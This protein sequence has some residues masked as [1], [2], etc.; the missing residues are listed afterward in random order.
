ME[1]R[2]EYLLESYFSNSL[3]EAEAAE[4]KQ[5]VAKDPG[6][7]EELSFQQRLASSL[8]KGALANS[9]QNKTWREAAKKPFSG[10]ALKIRMW[11]RYAIATAAAIALFLVAR[12]ALQT[13][14]LM[15]VVSE[16]TKEY[17]NTMP[18]KSLSDEA[19]R[20]PGE[21]IAAFALYDDKSY[22]KAATALEAIA[23]AYPEESDY[24]FY[25]GV[26]LVHDKQYDKAKSALEPLVQ[27][28]AEKSIPAR[29]YLG[30]AC[31]GT[32]DKDCAR[33]N[34]QSYVDSPEGV[35]YRKNAS[36]VLEGL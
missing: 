4:L 22:T 10:G 17:P 9:I 32:G 24:R 21:V 3:T 1:N 31:A 11:S 27:S 33:R 5:L 2:A 20:Y 16:N 30:L 7:A 8:Q 35:T 23:T 34:L 25:W 28:Q 13:P 6:I 15:T 26:A 14:D 29:Y 12:V 19:S 36:A 18:F